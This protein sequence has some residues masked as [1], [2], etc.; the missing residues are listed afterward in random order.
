M[1]TVFIGEKLVRLERKSI[2][3]APLTAYQGDLLDSI[4]HNR[5]KARLRYLLGR[6]EILDHELQAKADELCRQDLKPYLTLDD[7]DDNDPVLL[8]AMTIA[9]DLINS[10]M[11]QEGLPPPKGIDTHAKALVDNM[12][13]LQEQARLRVEARYKA[14]QEIIGK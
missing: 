13:E 4:L 1:L 5:V 9:R 6:G 11:A 2:V 14:A 7:G 3:G 12:P 10:R 8:E